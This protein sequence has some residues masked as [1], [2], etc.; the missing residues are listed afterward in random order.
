MNDKGKGKVATPSVNKGKVHPLHR[1]IKKEDD[2]PTNSYPTCGI[3]LEPFQATHSPVSAAR[4]ANSSARLP[5]GT[6][7]PCPRSHGYCIACLNTYI[8]PKLDPE[9]TGVGNMT[10]VIFPIRC[11]ECP[12]ADWPQGL[13]DTVAERVLSEKGMILWV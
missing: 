7:L 9:G 11:P 8:T 1:S 12:A 3:C 13:P 10:A 5:F 6:K 2:G 4:S